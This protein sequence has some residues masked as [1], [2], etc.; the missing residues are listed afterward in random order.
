MRDVEVIW[1]VYSV[2]LPDVRIKFPIRLRFISNELL[3][4]YFLGTSIVID[5]SVSGRRL[6]LDFNSVATEY[7]EI[8]S[9]R[10]VPNSSCVR[11]EGER[12]IQCGTKTQSVGATM[13]L[14]E[15]DA[16]IVDSSVGGLMTEWRLDR[17]LSR[18]R[19][20]AGP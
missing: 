10:S 15:C 9:E 11:E 17:E 1:Q 19:D 14:P 2:G 16:E 5:I 4:R 6:L 3:P 8:P 13:L 7:A 12:K 18:I 20:C